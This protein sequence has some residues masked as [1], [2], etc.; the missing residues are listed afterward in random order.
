MGLGAVWQGRL[1]S[2]PS[3]ARGKALWRRLLISGKRPAHRPVVPTGDWP[4]C[5]CSAAQGAAGGWVERTRV[6]PK[7][8]LKD[9]ERKSS[10]VRRLLASGGIGLGVLA[11]SASAAGDFGNGAM[12]HFYPLTFK[13]EGGLLR[14]Q[15]WHR[16]RA[17]DRAHGTAGQSRWAECG[18]SLV[19]EPRGGRG[20]GWEPRVDELQ[21]LCNE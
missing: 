4:A 8:Y 16:E 11:A 10:M 9:G 21:A 6:E 18:L 14:K 20:R 1:R 5:G 13:M 7:G 17:H 19:R 3:R 15:N 2:S 12:S